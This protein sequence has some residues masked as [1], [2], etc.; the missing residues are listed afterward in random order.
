MWFY[1]TSLIIVFFASLCSSPLWAQTDV[2]TPWQDTLEQ[3]AIDDE[4]GTQDWE[5]L[6]QDITERLQNPFNLNSATRQ[7]LEQLLFLTDIQIENILAYIYIHGQMQTIYELQLV[8]EM[9]KETIQRLLPFVFVASV[10]EKKSL[11]TLKQLIKY[12]KNEI[13]TRVDIPFYKRKGYETVYTGPS[14]YHSIRYNYHYKDNLYFGITAEKDAGEPFFALHNKK[15]YDFYSPFLLIRNIGKLKAFALGNYRLSFGQGLVISNDFLMGKT[16]TI[17]TLGNRLNSIKKHSSADEYNYFS[18]VAASVE[19]GDFVL[20]GFYSNRSFDAI[21]KEDIITSIQKTGLH[22]T[23]K[24]AERKSVANMQLT[25]GNLSYSKSKLRLGI[26]GVYYF[27]DKPYE[28]QLRE[29]SKYNLRGNYFHNLG[30]DYRYRWNRFTLTGETA[31]SKGNAL[32]AINMITYNAASSYQFT[33]LH[34]YYAHNYWGYFARSF[35]EGGYVQNENG[36][37]FAA[38]ASPLRRWKFFVSADF[39]SF[40]WLKYLVDKPSWGSDLQ[41]QITYSPRKNITMFVRYRYK[42]KEKNYTDEAKQKSVR[43]VYRHSFKYQLKYA[44]TSTFNL[45]TTFDF[46][47]VN[48]QHVKANKGMQFV[49]TLSWHPSS[50]PVKFEI[51]GAYFNTDNYDSRVYSYEKGLLN[52]FYV[53]SFYGE[54]LRFT[55]HLRCD[56]HKNWMLIGKIGQSRYF[57]RNEIGTGNDLIKGNKKTD[58]QLQLRIKF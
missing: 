37:Y 30:V 15:G 13:L 43:P 8:E 20:S 35:S 11:P 39:F 41:S 51:H 7:Q 34:R 16:T 42:R 33:L 46:N 18:G 47:S 24:E 49:Q 50:L 31:I 6:M 54:G 2:T 53:P 56:I 55:A 52:T 32:A 5:S 23:V 57:D 19:L 29:Y 26:T 12:G 44:V 40:P 21:I 14:L 22:R 45:R 9:D 58:L 38:E 3:L 10:E 17:S 48:P 25:C 4:D 36:W 27:F 28:P 1:R